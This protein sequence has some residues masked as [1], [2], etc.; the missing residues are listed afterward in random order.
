[1]PL[2]EVVGRTAGAS[3]AIGALAAGAL[4]PKCPLCIAAALSALG[5]G[6]AVGGALAP[7]VRPAALV[8]AVF[9]A[10]AFGRAAWRR[11]KRQACRCAEFAEAPTSRA[12]A[13]NS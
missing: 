10:A 11:R 8:V 13:P 1:M 7:Y 9:A 12:P 4:L 5:F 6:T 3:T 2:P